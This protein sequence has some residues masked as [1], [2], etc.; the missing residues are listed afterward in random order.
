MNLRRA[1]I[2]FKNQ[3][4]GLV[5]E[6]PQNG[7]LFTYQEG[8][9]E[10]IACALP[11]EEKRVE[12]PRGLHP[13]FQNL[14][15]EGWLRQQQARAGDV[16]KEDDFGL[17][18]RYGDDCIGAISVRPIDKPENEARKEPKTPSGN[19]LADAAT[20]DGR[21]VSGV[22]IKLLAWH[23]GNQFQPATEDSPATYI[24]KYAPLN[25]PTLLRNELLSLTLAR[26]I[27][28]PEEV[29]GFENG[30][31]QGIPDHA[32]LVE[33]FDRTPDGGKLRLEDFAQILVQPPPGNIFR[34]KYDGSYEEIAEGI[35]RYSARPAIDLA[36]FFS[37]LVFTLLIG[38]SDAHL[39]NWSLLE[40]PE[41]LRLSPQYD[42]LN[43]ALYRGDYGT[44]TALELCGSKVALDAVDRQLVL[45]FAEHIGLAQRAAE[46]RLENL[47]RRLARSDCLQPHPAESP[48][49]FLNRYS[50]VVGNACARI[51]EP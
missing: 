13:V 14:V 8:W 15:A 7:T 33:R 35:K 48:D 2:L 43:T 12:W 28:G 49:G 21:T 17:L 47:R 38:N 4:A 51:L 41:G 37:A 36:R 24:A 42:L 16:P 50:E 27:L 9:S 44:R 29:T 39:K 22:Q 32:L 31:V 26:E 18:L 1:H 5:E 3:I 45:H 10:T 23:D 6:T 46:L 34:G 25:E 20:I 40:R 11:I 19:D 30:P